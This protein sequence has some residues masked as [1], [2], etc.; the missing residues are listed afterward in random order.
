MKRDK[1][2]EIQ[3]IK[4]VTETER[5]NLK[6]EFDVKYEIVSKENLYLIDERKKTKADMR[7]L[8]SKYE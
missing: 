6:S 7:Q 1:D 3:H 5:L 2:L 4:L 8:Q